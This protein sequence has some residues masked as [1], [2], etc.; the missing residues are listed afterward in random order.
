MTRDGRPM[1]V[2]PAWIEAHCV[3]PDGFRRGAPLELYVF[4]RKFLGEHYRVRADA[5]W[6]PSAPILGPAFVHRVSML[7]GPQGLGKNP[8]IAAALCLEGVGPAL[9]AGW[10][11]PD[12][13]YACAEHGCGCGWEYAYDP[14]EPRGMQWPT[15]LIQVTAV[16]EDSTENTL[17]ALRPM[18]SEGP[19]ADVIPRTGEELIRLPGGGRID[20]V[21]SSAQ[22]RLG[23]PVTCAAQD[24]VGIWT[25]RNGMTKLADVQARGVAKM[26]GRQLR[27]TNAWDPTERSVAQVTY[28]S[29]VRVDDVYVQFDRPPANLSFA[30]KAERRRILHRVYP[31]D[32]LREHGGHV[33]LDA[34]EAEAVDLAAR[35][36]PQARRYFGNELVEGA[37]KAFDLERWKAAAVKARHVVP[38]RALVV[39]GF[40]GSKRHDHTALVAT[41]VASGFQWALGVWR[42]EDHGGEIPGDVVTATLEQAFADFDVWRVYA[43]PPYWEDT[44]A[45]W[46][47]RWGRERVVEWWTNR[48]KATAYAMRAWVEAMAT[49]SLSHCSTSEELCARVTEHVGN[50]IRHE[51]GYRDDG[52]PL[53]TV[54]KDG[55]NS[56]RKIDSVLAAV[57]SWEA[58][59]DALAAGALNLEDEASAWEERTSLYA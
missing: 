30:N 8:L 7:V 58:R 15:P 51:T 38:E 42:P 20:A 23:N 13:G 5:G 44:V 17:G 16:S 10:A 40:D 35:D 24:E 57:L 21:T 43:D 4:Q 41:E 27:T 55:P 18:I 19:L 31:P 12:E 39:I 26:S 36:L 49:G 6:I 46:A 34:I 50:A 56:P 29:R 14:G 33:D 37:G 3:V 47:G 28:E 2:G 48:A 54:E 59:N 25:P 52:G 32:T 1:V 45:S 53:W 9:F 11:G 22:A